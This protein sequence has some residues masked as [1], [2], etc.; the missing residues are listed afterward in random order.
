MVEIGIF[1]PHFT[2]FLDAKTV[3]EID[4]MLAYVTNRGFNKHQ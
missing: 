4:N 3:K 2:V 1:A